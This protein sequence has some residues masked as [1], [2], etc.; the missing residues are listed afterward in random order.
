MK[1]ILTG[2]AAAALA[3]MVGLSG[4]APASA[5][6]MP[7]LTMVGGADV[8]TVQ[9]DPDAPPPRR[10]NRDRRGHNG[11]RNDDRPGFRHGP[12]RDRRG[13]WNG[14]RGYE[15][16]RPGYRRHSDGFW[17]PSGAFRIR[18]Q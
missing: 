5:T 1:K 13:N 12:P 7:A 14:Y 8:A 17:Y 4:V 11:Y 2:F 16:R 9:Y 3:A 6:P 18:I 10:M 15:Q